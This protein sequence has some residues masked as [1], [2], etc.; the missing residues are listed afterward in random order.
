MSNS[1]PTIKECLVRLEERQKNQHTAMG[2][3]IKSA[4]ETSERTMQN[5]A[6]AIEKGFDGVGG[7]LDHHSGRIRAVE[8]KQYWF[9]GLAASA[10]ALIAAVWESM[11]N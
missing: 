5:M 9:A 7:R 10:G 2:E 4:A 3:Q 1:S 11:K 6:E 8:N